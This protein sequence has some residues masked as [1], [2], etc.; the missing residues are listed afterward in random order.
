[1]IKVDGRFLEVTPSL[2]VGVFRAERPAVW[3][4]SIALLGGLLLAL[5]GL[6]G[7]GLGT[8][9]AIGG[10]VLFFAAAVAA[11]AERYAVTTVTGVAA[12]VWTSAG[13]S[14]YLGVDRSLFLSFLALAVVGAAV[15]VVGGL[16]AVRRRPGNT[17]RAEPTP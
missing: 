2:S 15:S 1:V 12:M 16:G 5:G 17:S 10:V 9:A 6:V 8:P 13:V 14:V 4:S 7:A 3:W 11:G